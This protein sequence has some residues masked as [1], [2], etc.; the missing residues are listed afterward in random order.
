[1][2]AMPSLDDKY[3]ILQKSCV[4]FFGLA[5][6]IFGLA[7]TIFG[8]ALTIFGLALTIFGLALTIFGLAPTISETI[9]FHICYFQKV[10]KVTEFSFCDGEYRNLQKLSNGLLR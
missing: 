3:R 1:M 9:T 5:L 2:F 10:G 7:L 4:A 8:L 6:T